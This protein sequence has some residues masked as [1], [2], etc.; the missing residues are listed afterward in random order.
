MV[1]ENHM[2][3]IQL[4]ADNEFFSGFI[5]QYNVQGI[6]KFILIDPDGNIVNS[7]APR[8]SDPEL[9]VLLGGLKL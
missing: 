1:D 2:G 8:P 4:I 3:G 7:T 6:P 5:K 9:L